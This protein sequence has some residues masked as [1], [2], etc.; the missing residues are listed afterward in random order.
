M[1]NDFDRVHANHLSVVER[2]IANFAQITLV[3]LTAWPLLGKDI[4]PNKTVLFERARL[5]F[6]TEF[7]LSMATAQS[8]LGV[9]TV[10]LKKR[11]RPPCL[12]IIPYFSCS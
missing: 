1:L 10:D 6:R 3:T 7:F 5:T 9:V 11:Q 8:F 12:R 4:E 2:V